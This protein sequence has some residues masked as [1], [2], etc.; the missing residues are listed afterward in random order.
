MLNTWYLEGERYKGFDQD[1]EDT[2]FSR[3]EAK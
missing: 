1:I 2:L 3:C